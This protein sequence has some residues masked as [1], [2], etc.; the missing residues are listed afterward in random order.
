MNVTPR[1]P[2]VELVAAACE[3]FDKEN[4]LIEQALTEL[5]HQ[6]PKNANLSHVLLKVVALDHLYTT[7]ILA[8]IDVAMN[9]Q[10][11][12][13][14]AALAAGSPEII[15]EIAKVKIKGKIRNNYSFATKYC[16]W[17]NPT[18]YPIW[19]SRVDAYLWR[20]QKHAQF[21]TDFN[22]NEDLWSYGKFRGIV[23]QLRDRYGLGSFS[24]KQIDKFLYTEGEL[25]LSRVPITAK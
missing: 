4:N 23:N 16:S 11:R 9:I 17:H 12:D 6:F 19:D 7:R 3:Q 22:K 25:L 20:L 14:D 8:S 18:A 2:T 24:F 5:F 10:A 21:A 1:E 15:D 13:I